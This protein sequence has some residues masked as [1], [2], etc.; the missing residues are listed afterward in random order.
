MGVEDIVEREAKSNVL[1]CRCGHGLQDCVCACVHA[2][3][4]VCVFICVLACVSLCICVLVFLNVT[5]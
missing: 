5:V 2:R 4:C 3:V 1:W